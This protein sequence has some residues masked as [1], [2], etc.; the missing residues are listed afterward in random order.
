MLND[1]FK[2]GCAGCIGGGVM[3]FVE[4]AFYVSALIAATQIVKWVWSW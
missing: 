1:K 4:L 3:L 2:D